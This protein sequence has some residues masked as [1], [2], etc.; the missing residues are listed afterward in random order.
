M[1]SILNIILG[2]ALTSQ[3]TPPRYFPEGSFDESQ[4]LSE[5]RDEWYSQ[6]LRKLEEPSLLDMSKGKEIQVYR[7]LWLRAFHHPVCI[8]L[9][10]LPDGT[11]ILT[12]KMLGG[13]DGDKDA[14]LIL[15]DRQ[16]LNKTDWFLTFLGKQGF[17]GIKSFDHSVIGFDGAEWI[18]EGAKDGEYHVVDRWSPKDGPVYSLGMAMLR[19]SRL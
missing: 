18:I 1:S 4:K 5:R 2:I 16:V 3:T 19:M 15:N 12:T 17:W 8:R 10:V 6:E 13:V 11:G 14:K 9:D 7:F